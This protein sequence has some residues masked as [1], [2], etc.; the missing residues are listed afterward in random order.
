[1]MRMS[2]FLTSRFSFEASSLTVT[3]G[4]TDS[5]LGVLIFS[6]A[7][8]IMCVSRIVG[9]RKSSTLYIYCLGAHETVG[10]VLWV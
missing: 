1:M 9:P 7:A 2:S 6:S 5:E 10:G 8:I 4:P 3:S